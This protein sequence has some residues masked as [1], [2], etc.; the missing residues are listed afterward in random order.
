[1]STTQPP[2]FST[3]NFII[4][5]YIAEH[6]IWRRARHPEPSA[7]NNHY[8]PTSQ[9]PLIQQPYGTFTHSYTKPI[10]STQATRTAQHL[11][12]PH[13]A[14][15]PSQTHHNNPPIPPHNSKT[16]IQNKPPTRTRKEN[17]LPRSNTEIPSRRR[18]RSS[19]PP[20]HQH[21]TWKGNTHS[22]TQC[23]LNHTR[24]TQR[25]PPTPP[26]PPS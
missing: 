15:H 7:T 21:T 4:V 1:M 26:Q 16:L 19:N 23:L 8:P 2:H 20:T 17:H 3:N 11:Q 25:S 6:Q 22:L 10:P 9:S 12:T 5:V 14:T 13:T 24:K 18:I